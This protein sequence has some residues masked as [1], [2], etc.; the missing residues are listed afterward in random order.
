M[1][2]Q[3]EVSAR[4]QHFHSQVRETTVSRPPPL[5]PCCQPLPCP[6]PRPRPPPPPRAPGPRGHAPAPPPAAPGAPALGAG[7]LLPR[8]PR[9]PRLPCPGPPAPE[10]RWAQRR[11]VGPADPPAGSAAQHLRGP[12]APFSERGLHAGPRAC[13]TWW[14]PGPDC[15]APAAPL[16]G[17]APVSQHPAGL[18]G[19]PAVQATSAALGAVVRGA[20]LRPCR[21]ARTWLCC[22]LPAHRSPVRSRL[23]LRARSAPTSGSRVRPQARRRMESSAAGRP[24]VSFLVLQVEVTWRRRSSES[25]ALNAAGA[26]PWR[27]CL[28]SDGRLRSSRAGLRRVPFA[29]ARVRLWRGA[30]PR[31]GTALLP[32]PEARAGVRSHGSACG[33][34]L[35]PAPPAL[36]SKPL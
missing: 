22:P 17:S 2:G 29:G 27:S 30:A 1:E 15:R 8:A 9:A 23:C 6:G 36:S 11:A 20:R 25:G 18:G 19:S 5:R 33:R 35:L 4:E 14:R 10:L 34:P 16:C 12:L 24:L 28:S 32:L 31:G 13:G 26:G 3:D 21:S 7:C